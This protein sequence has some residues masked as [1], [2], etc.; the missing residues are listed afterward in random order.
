M[1]DNQAALAIRISLSRQRLWLLEGNDVVA[2]YPVSTAAKPQPM[3][4]VRRTAACARRAVG[5]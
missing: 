2:D 1:S 5:T 3:G 4:P